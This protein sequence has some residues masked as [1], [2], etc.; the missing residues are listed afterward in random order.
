MSMKSIPKNKLSE[1][2]C[3][4][5]DLNLYSDKPDRWIYPNLYTHKPTGDL[6]VVAPHNISPE[7]F[8]KAFYGLSTI[9]NRPIS[10][11]K[12]LGNHR[13]LLLENRLPDLVHYHSRPEHIPLGHFWLGTFDDGSPVILA[14][15][16]SPV[17]LVAGA[18]GSGKSEL[19]KVLL[20]EIERTWGA[21]T[22]TIAEG[23]KD[24]NDFRHQ[25]CKRLAT[26]IESV[27]A[28]YQELESI[29][30]ERKRLI[31]EL[32][33]DNWFEARS[34]GCDWKP[35]ILLVD[36]C[37]LFLSTPRKGDP[38]FEAKTEIIR[39]A[40]HLAMRGRYVGLLQILGTQDPS[41]TGL[42][43]DIMNQVRLK[44]GYGMRT[45]E[46]ARAYFGQA[47]PHAHDL[48]QGKGIAMLGAEPKI[49]RGAFIRPQK[50]PAT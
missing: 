22:I 45:A 10:G 6:V 12:D 41:S 48:Q 36:E 38:D 7:K 29:Y 15:D 21:D 27:L 46:M 30:E 43:S 40:S 17:F 3:L 11:I 16:H 19:F 26:D 44:V 1:C 14:F 47:A 50:K 25:K 9:F 20:K 28:V 8:E 37:P 23:T 4:F 31:R 2:L 24:G 34:K 42:P 39:I 5:N 32:D 35:H 18:S 33:V 13:W 49:F